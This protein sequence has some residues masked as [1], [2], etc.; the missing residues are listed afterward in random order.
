MHRNVENQQTGD[1][2]RQAPHDTTE[3]PQNVPNGQTPNP[4]ESFTCTICK[5]AFLSAHEL[6]VHLKSHKRFM[7]NI[8]DKLLTSK[9]I[10]SVHLRIHT[11]EKPF[12]CNHCSY[13]AIKKSVLVEHTKKSHL[14]KPFQCTICHFRFA[15][16]KDRDLH[17]KEHKF[18]CTICNLKLTKKRALED[19]VQT[20]TRDNLLK[21]AHCD[22]TCIQRGGLKIHLKTHNRPKAGFSCS[23]CNH[24]AAT[25]ND[26][27]AH[28]ATHSKGSRSERLAHDNEA[29]SN[30]IPDCNISKHT[31]SSKPENSNCDRRLSSKIIVCLTRLSV[32]NICNRAFA[33]KHALT[34]HVLAHAQTS[35]V[36]VHSNKTMFACNNCDYKGTSKGNLRGHMEGH[37]KKKHACSVCSYKT[38][39]KQH[40]LRHFR[41]KH[42]GEKPFVCNICNKYRTSNK[43][44]L[45]LHLRTHTGERPHHCDICEAKF[46]LYSNLRRH[47]LGHIAVHLNNK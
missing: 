10:L 42:S 22:F 27:I 5:N 11:Q 31:F 33:D 37:G 38:S 15:Q 29:V 47:K 20:H 6:T 9:T 24:S 4:Q 35:S 44:G 7:C 28:L 3:A 8:C 17:I 25:K 26:F 16:K 46:T 36:K 13:K 40:L 18:A 30:A 12:A 21:C 39:R 1:T 41:Y 34:Q 19:H 43:C 2:Q 23:I 32:C 45:R 14:G